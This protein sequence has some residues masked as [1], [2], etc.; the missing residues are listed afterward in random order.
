MCVCG[1][2]NFFTVGYYRVLVVLQFALLPM[3]D[4]LKLGTNL[5]CYFD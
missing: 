5:L 3:A 4:E 1:N 2:W